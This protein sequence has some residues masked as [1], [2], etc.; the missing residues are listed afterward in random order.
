MEIIF[1]ILSFF[2]KNVKISKEIFEFLLHEAK[3]G[4]IM[5]TSKKL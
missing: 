1:I 5:E 4:A 2:S 3:E